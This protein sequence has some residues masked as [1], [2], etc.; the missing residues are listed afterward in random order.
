MK[1]EEKT[2]EK[3]E[4]ANSENHNSNEKHETKHM[5]N[6]NV[7]KPFQSMELSELSSKRILFSSD[8]PYSTSIYLHICL[9]RKFDF[10]AAEHRNLPMIK[11]M[12]IQKTKCIIQKKNVY[13]FSEKTV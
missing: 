7:S 8:D 12:Y 5:K 1:G 10:F 9:P 11:N 3:T 13:T 4:N 2:Y 6:K